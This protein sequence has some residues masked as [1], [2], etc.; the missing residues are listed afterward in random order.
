[1]EN[2][3]F[4]ER[5]ISEINSYMKA[6]EKTNTSAE[7][8]TVYRKYEQVIS[9]MTP[10][11]IFYLEDFQDQ[12]TLS[13]SEIKATANRFVNVFHKGLS[14]Y[15]T[16]LY[17]QIFIELIK[18]NRA[19]E[20]HLNALKQFLKKENPLDFQKQLLEG[21]RK[22]SVV[23][24]KYSKFEN[25]IFPNLESKTPSNKPFEVLWD[26][27][28]DAR[29]LLKNIINLLEQKAVEKKTLSEIVGK[30][31]F[32]IF[33]INQKEELIILPTMNILLDNINLDKIFNEC[34]DVGFA[35][36]TQ[37]LQKKEV[38][39]TNFSEGSF[40]TETGSLSFENLSAMLNHLPVDITFV[41]K[42]DFVRYYN[43]SKNRHFPRNPSVIGRLVK[44]CHPP[45]S[46]DV[47]EKIISD[48]KNNKKDY[49]EFWI[50]F[51]EKMLYIIYYAIRDDERN[52]L[53]VLEVSQDVTKFLNLKGEKRL[54]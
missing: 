18:E 45:K 4:N 42:D 14:K 51:K 15:T 31:Y 40:K 20:K 2:F 44:N 7:K 17:H 41:D 32:M 21:F 33:G 43:Q 6:I 26:L 8:V 24:Q 25:I 38:K 39:I 11:D 35:F 1:M 28:D 52:Y 3:K 37:T 47:V 30:Y 27:H 23:E 46:V 19:I 53:G 12:T 10:I 5:R 13:I 16:G 29:E 50:N 54:L 48:F 36:N 34:V 49:E 22:C 9:E